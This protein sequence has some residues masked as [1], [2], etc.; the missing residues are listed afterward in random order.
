MSILTDEKLIEA[1]FKKY[2]P[3]RID[4]YDSLFQLKVTDEIGIKYFIDVEKWDM[5]KLGQSDNAGWQV[6]LN[7]NEG[8]SWHSPACI[9]VIAGNVEFWTVQN[10]L[11]WAEGVWKRLE[12]S[13]YE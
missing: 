11:D 3:S 4:R 10:I 2:I 9:Q 6:E 1:G 8:S 13:Y 7:F 5:T 12:P